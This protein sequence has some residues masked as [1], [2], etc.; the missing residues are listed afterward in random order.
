MMFNS[1]G[2]LISVLGFLAT[3]SILNANLQDLVNQSKRL[4]ENAQNLRGPAPMPNECPVLNLQTLPKASCSTFENRFVEN[5]NDNVT[6]YSANSDQSCSQ[7]LGFRK[8]VQGIFKGPKQ[9]PSIGYQVR[10]FG[11]VTC[12]YALSKGYQEVLNT[13]DSVVV[14]AAELPSKAHANGPIICPSL[15]KELVK[16][17]IFDVTSPK[18]A[19]SKNYVFKRLPFQTKK[20]LGQGAK[21]LLT[22]SS[23]VPLPPL[24]K[25][26]VEI[27]KNFEM[28]CTYKHNSGGKPTQLELIG[29][30]G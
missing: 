3:T 23:K 6:Y 11:E 30:T 7:G 14:F 24:E 19:G 22:P 20:G 1:K 9:Y 29:T 28:S 15:S 10:S 18:W 13:N 4:N 26:K 27:T 17:G 16:D 12:T 5:P 2:L 8:M 21:N 25:G